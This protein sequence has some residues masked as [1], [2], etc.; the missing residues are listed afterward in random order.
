MARLRALKKKKQK[1]SAGSSNSKS[2]DGKSGSKSKAGKKQLTAFA[3]MQSDFGELE[4]PPYVKLNQDDIKEDKLLDF[5]FTIAPQ[6][7]Y[8]KGG[9]FHFRCQVPDDYPYKPPKILCLDKIY[10]P[11]LDLEGN[12][13]LNILRQDWKPVLDTQSIIH[14]LI[15]LFVEPNPNDPLN[16][17]AAKLMRDNKSQFKSNV[18]RS[19][20]GK[21]VEGESYQRVI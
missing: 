4:L 11:N 1:E 3:R 2:A 7:G 21:M 10:H 17:E 20:Q 18:L 19:M 14:G 5:R 6:D 13:C 9:T 8:W 12:V 15:Y 16:K